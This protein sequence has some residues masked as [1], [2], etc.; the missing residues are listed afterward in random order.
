MDAGKLERQ[1]ASVERGIA[2]LKQE[3]LAML[4]GLQLEITHLRRRCHGQS[5]GDL[6]PDRSTEEEEAE[7]AAR[8]EAA[9]RLL[10]EQQCMMVTT[11]GELRAGRAR[12]SALGRSLRE[13]ERHFLEELKR[14]SH[15][16]TLLSRE[17][18]RQNVTTTT[19]CHEL[20]TA[21]LKLYQQQRGTESGAEGEEEPRTTEEGEEDRDDEG[22][23]C[24][25]DE[26]YEEEGSDWLLSPPPPASPSQREPKCSIQYNPDRAKRNSAITDFF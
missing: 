18:H 2:F 13:E 12:A 17:L 7:L 14:R 20:H 11:R 26:D 5:T 1:V 16:I 10:Q 8:C 19:L 3:H 23:E 24:E 4:A 21:R 22:D 25:E 6:F 15:K 9:Q